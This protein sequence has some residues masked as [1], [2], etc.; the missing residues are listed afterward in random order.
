MIADWATPM[1]IV[2]YRPEAIDAHGY[3]VGRHPNAVHRPI[4]LTAARPTD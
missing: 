2:W 1:P 3:E 4:D